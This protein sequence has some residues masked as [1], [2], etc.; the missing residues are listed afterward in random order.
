MKKVF[1][2]SLVAIVAT[3]GAQALL[4]QA[5]PQPS[6]QL[7]ASQI[8]S[9]L[10]NAGYTQIT[11]VEKDDGVWE[12]DAVSPKGERVEIDLDPVSGKIIR[13]RPNDDD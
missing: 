1:A 5:Q 9:L 6:Q 3:F 11:D 12:V 13:E 2:G 7:T 8:I 4:A 10:E